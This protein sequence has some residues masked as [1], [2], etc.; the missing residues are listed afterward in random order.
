MFATKKCQRLGDLA[1]GTVVVSEQATDYSARSDRRVL[2]EWEAE[3]GAAALRA[4]GLTPDEYRALSNYWMRR[5]ELTLEARQNVLPKLVVPILTRIGQTLA[6]AR[7]ETL[8]AYVELLMR[9]AWYAEN[10]ARARQYQ[11]YQHDQ[12]YYPRGR[13]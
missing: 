10:E 1:A 7:F 4:T 11:Q 8:E 5:G 13:P 3:A 2:A 9:Q 6:D 12:Q